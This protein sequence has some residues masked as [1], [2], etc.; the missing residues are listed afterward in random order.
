MKR[1]DI[2]AAGIIGE[3]SMK[4]ELTAEELDMVGGGVSDDA[5]YG[6][7]LGF[8]VAGVGALLAVPTMGTSTTLV[9]WGSSLAASALALEIATQ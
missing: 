2:S 3:A 6:A 1:S 5:L 8:A 4:R 9:V 7:A